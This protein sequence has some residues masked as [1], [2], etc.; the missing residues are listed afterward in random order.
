M[1]TRYLVTQAF[2]AAL[3]VALL[4]AFSGLSFGV[5]QFRVAEVLLLLVFF[6]KRHSV[7]IILGTLVGNLMF[8]PIAL[9]WILGTLATGIALYLMILIKEELLALL[10]PSIVNGIIVGLQLT[11]F[12]QVPTP[13]I[14]N[15]GSVFIG[16]FV[17]TFVAGVILLPMLRKNKPLVTMLSK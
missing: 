17:V 4:A 8:S 13:L 3:Y 12:Y 9:D 2:I 5:I 14:M 16:E 15:I 10:M 11:Y 1:N 6:N 7:G